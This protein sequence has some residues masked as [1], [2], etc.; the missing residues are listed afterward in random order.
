MG[1]RVQ[2]GIPN[3]RLREQ[4]EQRY[5]TQAELAEKIGVSEM[6]VG[7]WERGEASPAPYAV[8]KLCV[9]FDTTPQELGLKRQLEPLAPLLVEIDPPTPAITVTRSELEATVPFPTHSSLSAPA[10]RWPRRLVYTFAL[11]LLVIVMLSMAAYVMITTTTSSPQKTIKTFCQALVEKDFRTAYDQ[12]SGRLQQQVPMNEI[13][14]AYNAC[15]TSPYNVSA[16]H[17]QCTLIVTTKSNKKYWRLI[18]LAQDEHQL[19][20]IDSWG[21]SHKG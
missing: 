14:K 7:R 20:K 10:P 1:S 9:F 19:W 18:T 4:R 2:K 8:K 12:F 21:V 5:L 15:T 3:V 17:P 6:T 13:T 11:A 16:A